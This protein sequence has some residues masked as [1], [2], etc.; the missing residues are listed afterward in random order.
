LNAT[1]KPFQA[2][3]IRVGEMLQTYSDFSKYI[4]G[5][6]IYMELATLLVASVTLYFVRF[7][8]L[9]APIAFVMFFI[10]VSSTT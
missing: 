2:F 4:S 3:G 5:G 7:P 1:Y 10:S 9:T 6:W 8:F